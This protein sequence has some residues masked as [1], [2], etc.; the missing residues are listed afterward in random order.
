M[1][2]TDK[3]WTFEFSRK[4]QKQF[5]KLDRPTKI[6]IRDYIQ[7]LV[8]SDQNPKTQAK[9]LVGE[10]NGFYRFRVGDYRLICLMQ[11]EC[12]T[13]LA[14]HIAHRRDVYDFIPKDEYR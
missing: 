6:R 2:K 1:S 5:E 14:V 7:K 12:L 13:I 3:K 8:E 4:A 9:P 11:D 10:L